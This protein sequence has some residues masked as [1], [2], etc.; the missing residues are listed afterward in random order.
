MDINILNRA[1]VQIDNYTGKMY[2]EGYVMPY[3]FYLNNID[4]GRTRIEVAFIH[5]NGKHFV[6][7]IDLNDLIIRVDSGTYIYSSYYICIK[8]V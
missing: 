4:K 1:L 7:T 6:G 5:I 2:S 3:D 8:E